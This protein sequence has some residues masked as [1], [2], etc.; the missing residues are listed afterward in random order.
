MTP[1]GRPCAREPLRFGGIRR[2][3]WWCTLHRTGSRACPSDLLYGASIPG[4]PTSLGLDGRPSS[5]GRRASGRDLPSQLPPP[6]A[7]GDH[8]V[9]VVL[10]EPRAY[11]PQGSEAGVNMYH[12]RLRSSS[13]GRART[14]AP[15][16]SRS[17]T[18]R[19]SNAPASVRYSKWRTSRQKYADRRSTC[20]QGRP[21][22]Y[23][24]DHQAPDPAAVNA[25]T[26]P[27][28]GHAPG[29]RRRRWRRWRTAAAQTAAARTPTER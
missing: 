25:Y 15:P 27:V 13:A 4:R 29:A 8:A 11:S 17:P 10:M 20:P 2:S 12:G 26:S 23:T 9:S 6:L 3:G 16:R 22:P 21:A 14:R 28:T 18:C 1:N 7:G 19:S 24:L 5:G